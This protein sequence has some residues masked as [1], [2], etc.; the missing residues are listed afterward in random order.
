MSSWSAVSSWSEWRRCCIATVALS[1]RTTRL[2]KP[3]IACAARFTSERS[4]AE[5]LSSGASPRVRAH[6]RADVLRRR[7]P[8]D[9]DGEDVSRRVVLDAPHEKNEAQTKSPA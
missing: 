6:Q 3:G 7:L 1:Q 8:R 4:W 9:A 2:L 5:S